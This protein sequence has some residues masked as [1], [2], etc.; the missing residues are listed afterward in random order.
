MR[1]NHHS[2]IRHFFFFFF[3][4][5]FF[6]AFLTVLLLLF[7]FVRL[8]VCSLTHMWCVLRQTMYKRRELLFVSK[9]DILFANDR[10][11]SRQ[12]LIITTHGTLTCISNFKC[13][14]SYFLIKHLQSNRK[15]I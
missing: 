10:R 9:E 2:K 7:F 6:F 5:S 1:M 11:S 3:D 4:Q 14:I 8:F 15:S 12:K 13:L